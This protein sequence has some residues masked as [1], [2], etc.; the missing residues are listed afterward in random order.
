VKSDAPVARDTLAPFNQVNALSPR[1]S[2]ESSE[3]VQSR[4]AVCAAGWGK[5]PAEELILMRGSKRIAS[6]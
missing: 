6:E 3:Q 2:A 4:R 1:Q 5:W